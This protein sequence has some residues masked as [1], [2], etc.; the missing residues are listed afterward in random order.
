ML[1]LVIW[2]CFTQKLRSCVAAVHWQEWNGANSLGLAFLCLPYRCHVTSA[3]SAQWNQPTAHKIHRRCQK[4]E[5]VALPSF[6][7]CRPGILFH[8]RRY[9][10]TSIFTIQFRQVLKT[11]HVSAFWKLYDV[12]CV[13]VHQVDLHFFSTNEYISPGYTLSKC[14]DD[15]LTEFTLNKWLCRTRHHFT[16]RPS[17]YKR[18]LFYS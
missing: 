15:R 11:S 17:V 3:R 9:K 13:S 8:R 5:Q 2:W 1:T 16:W 7:R 6:L 12:V 18:I 4:G 14:S 10:M